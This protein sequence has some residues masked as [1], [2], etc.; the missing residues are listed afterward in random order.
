MWNE[1]YLPSACTNHHGFRDSKV[2]RNYS[3]MLL[4]VY[5]G[6]AKFLLHRA[7]TY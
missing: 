2:K 6:K 5:Q 1:I 4:A 7:P 3:V